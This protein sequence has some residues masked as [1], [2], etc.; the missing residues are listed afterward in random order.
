MPTRELPLTVLCILLAACLVPTV[1]FELGNNWGGYTQS[2]GDKLDWTRDSAGTPS[3]NTGPS[4]DVTPNRRFGF[5]YYLF[6]ET[7]VSAAAN[8]N[9]LLVSPLYNKP[10]TPASCQYTFY[11]SMYGAT[12][13]TLNVYMRVK[14]INT[15]MFSKKGNQGKLWQ[16]ST[17]KVPAKDDFQVCSRHLLRLSRGTWQQNNPDCFA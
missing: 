14:G 12:V 11:Y 10:L 4:T 6:L 5:G 17:F 8:A 2:K 15:P 7:S 3:S 16:Y 13:N 1:T 9:A